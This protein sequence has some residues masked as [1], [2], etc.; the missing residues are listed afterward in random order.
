MY[1]AAAAAAAGMDARLP[2]APTRACTR[3]PPHPAPVA[4]VLQLTAALRG[5]AAR[6]SKASGR[7]WSA[8]QVEQA[9]VGNGLG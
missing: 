4:S 6:L 5:K 2:T 7:Q 8:K 3:T 9:R 1:G